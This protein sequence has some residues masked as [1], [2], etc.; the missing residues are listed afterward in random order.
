MT[1]TTTTT[2]LLGKSLKSSSGAT[3]P[4]LFLA[5]KQQINVLLCEN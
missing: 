4:I 1:T 2:T 5:T 3:V